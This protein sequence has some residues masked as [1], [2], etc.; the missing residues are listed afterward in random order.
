MALHAPA[1]PHHLQTATQDGT[2]TSHYFC[3]LLT[4][5]SSQRLLCC[6]YFRYLVHKVTWDQSRMDRQFWAKMSQPLKLETPTNLT[7]DFR[8][9][10]NSHAN[11]NSNTPPQTT[12]SPRHSAKCFTFGDG[13]ALVSMSASMSAVGQYT[14]CRVLF[15]TTQRIKWQCTSICLVRAWYWW[16]RVNA[17]ADWLSKKSIIASLNGSKISASRLWS[18][19]PSF[20]PCVAATYL[21][22]VV[23]REMISC[24]FEDQDTAPPSIRN[25]NP[26]IAQRSSDILP[27]ASAYPTNACRASP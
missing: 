8:T 17:M 27:L 23:D 22:S 12:R 18:Q 5:I 15:S 2:L 3:T 14:R 26:V 13:S 24:F 20:M 21:L 7:S 4:R 10:I 9:G 6:S 1:L 11:S 19:S 25:A 16:L